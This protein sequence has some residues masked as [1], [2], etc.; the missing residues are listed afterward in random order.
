[1]TKP[2]STEKMKLYMRER[3][4]KLN[5]LPVNPVVVPIPINHIEPK[6][7]ITKIIIKNISII[8]REEHFHVLRHHKNLH[9]VLPHLLET[10]YQ[11]NWFYLNDI[12][13]EEFRFLYRAYK[14]NKKYK[15]QHKI[16]FLPVLNEVYEAW[17]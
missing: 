3:R 2:Y 9:I 6:K 12:M 14:L 17:L 10:A 4:L 8:D 16:K 15:L 7:I 13:K 1:M 5:P 11:F